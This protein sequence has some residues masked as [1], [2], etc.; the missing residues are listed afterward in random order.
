MAALPGT[1]RKRKVDA[2]TTVPSALWV[3][4]PVYFLVGAAVFSFAVPDCSAL[5]SSLA[6]V[7]LMI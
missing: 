7:A 4:F 6:C 3:M 1:R 2:G 5:S